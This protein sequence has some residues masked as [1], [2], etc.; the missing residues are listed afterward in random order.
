MRSGNERAATYG[1]IPRPFDLAIYG[2]G[3]FPYGC[4]AHTNTLQVKYGLNEGFRH[5]TAQITIASQYMQAAATWTLYGKNPST[6][7][8][9]QCI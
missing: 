9:L 3:D 6:N 5:Q 4:C 1:A 7:A 8:K 2:A